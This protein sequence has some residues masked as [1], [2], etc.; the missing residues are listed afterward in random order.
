[1]FHLKQSFMKKDLLRLPLTKMYFLT[2]VLSATLLLYACGD[3][4]EGRVEIN[5]AAP[6]QVSNVQTAP[7]P[8]EVYLTWT[9]P[10]SDSFMYTKIE[11]EDSKGTG[12]YVIVSKERVNESGQGYAT[13]QGFANTET[14]NF[15]LYACSVRGNNRGAVE[16]SQAPSIPAFQEVI[17]SITVEPALG[18]VMV[19]WDNEFNT[20]VQVA[21]AYHSVADPSKA[22]TARFEAAPGKGSRLQRLTYG[23]NEAISGEACVIDVT[24]GDNFENVS[25]VRTVNVTPAEAKKLDRSQWSFPGYVADSNSGT[26]GYSSQEA[27]GEGDKDGLPN[28]RVVSMIDESLNTFWHASWKEASNY[29]HWFILDMGRDVMVSS[30]ELTR[31]LGDARGQTGQHI[32]TCTNADAADKSN[33][34][35]WNW[36]DHGSSSF[37]NTTDT[38][39]S[40]GLSSPMEVRYIKVYFG[41]EHKGSGAQAML[42][43]LNVYGLE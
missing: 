35:S 16:V 33:P 13:V 22:G 18:G 25:E 21:L 1:M 6:A 26:I 37:D 24:T 19:N 27:K 10:S 11:Y 12:R 17:N 9:N 40:I 41:T 7:G 42:S 36:V 31:R 4:A 15:S 28:G 3:D 2:A 8:G 43:D 14:V 39:Q 32:Y 20:S 30:V 29:P 38:P 5:D 34:D 23:D